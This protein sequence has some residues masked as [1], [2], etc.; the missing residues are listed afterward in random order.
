MI[1]ICSNQCTTMYLKEDLGYFRNQCQYQSMNLLEKILTLL[2]NKCEEV[3][4]NLEK[5]HGS[6]KLMKYISDD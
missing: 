1:E 5:T 4:V 2:R 6:D 3:Y